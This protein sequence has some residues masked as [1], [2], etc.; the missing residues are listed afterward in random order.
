MFITAFYDD[1]ATPSFIDNIE[2]TAV[3]IPIVCELMN[4]ETSKIGL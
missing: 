2:E 1:F 4:A 3:E